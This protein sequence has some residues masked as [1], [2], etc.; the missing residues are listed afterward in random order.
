VVI[1]L[2]IFALRM[3][4]NRK[5]AA[6]LLMLLAVICLLLAFGPTVETS[7]NTPSHFLSVVLFPGKL[8]LHLTAVRWPIRIFM[9]VALCFA[10]LAGLGLT[11]LQRLVPTRWQLALASAMI[12]ALIVE[13][14]PAAWYSRSSLAMPDPIALSD[15]YPFLAGE[16]S[17]G[18][19]VE[20]PSATDS[21]RAPGYATRYAYA[22]AGHL[23]GVVAFHGSLFPP[24]LKTMR[25]ATYDLPKPEA[26]RLM[27]GNGVTRV[28][29]HKDLMSADSA[30]MLVSAFLVDG[31]SLL[32]VSPRSAVIALKNR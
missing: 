5:S 1:V 27:K 13:L 3:A 32:F 11:Q 6:P 14:R 16:K 2:S 8:W 26:I 21:G 17:R 23:R 25:E 29:I 10:L 24:L 9:Y 28:V 22:S 15:S 31:D 4:G 7:P 18:G 20:L 12:A 30:N 19:V